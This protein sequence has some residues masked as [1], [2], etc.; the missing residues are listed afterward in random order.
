MKRLERVALVAA[1][2]TVVLGFVPATQA[3]AD[4]PTLV[5]S[6][7]DTAYA[8]NST[9]P[10]GT[11]V[12][13]DVDL[14]EPIFLTG[15]ERTLLGSPTE[16]PLL[17]ASNPTFIFSS[18]GTAWFTYQWTSGS[19]WGLNN[20]STHTYVFFATEGSTQTGC[21]QGLGY[22]PNDNWKAYWYGGGSSCGHSGSVLAPWG[23]CV[24]IPK[25][26]AKTAFSPQ[27]FAGQW[28]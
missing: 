5:G 22:N 25:L 16:T 13:D 8:D 23:N 18:I 4:G 17:A 20:N 2:L 21:V 7:R 24:G 1:S 26:R 11:F 3:S 15:G 12:A 19:L 6:Q 14:T 28:R 9:I 10:D 27:L